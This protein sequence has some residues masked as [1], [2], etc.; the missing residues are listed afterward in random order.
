MIMAYGYIN[1]KPGPNA[2]SQNNLQLRFHPELSVLE[3]E[4][5]QTTGSFLDSIQ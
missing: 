1:M 5:L 2:M 4:I 3:D